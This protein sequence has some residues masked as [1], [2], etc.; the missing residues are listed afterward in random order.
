MKCIGKSVGEN[1][2]FVAKEELLS[3]IKEFL[4]SE[5]FEPQG[6]DGVVFVNNTKDACEC[7][8][9]PVF[10]TLTV[11][12]NVIELRLSANWAF[13]EGMCEVYMGPSGNHEVSTSFLFPFGEFDEPVMYEYKETFVEALRN[14]VDAF[15]K[16]ARIY[17]S[18][19]MGEEVRIVRPVYAPTCHGS[20]PFGGF[21]KI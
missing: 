9:T 8:Y 3:I 15:Y 10:A 21:S 19:V 14:Y 2:R 12:D 4:A 6:E 17:R 11:S 20:S 7:F 18:V 5:D 16:K 1:T 13:N